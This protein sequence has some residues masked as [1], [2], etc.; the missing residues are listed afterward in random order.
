MCS[1]RLLAKK[2]WYNI[3]FSLVTGHGWV[4]T[5]NE[6]DITDMQFNILLF[7]MIEHSHD[8]RFSV[9]FFF[10]SARAIR[11]VTYAG[12]IS[13]N[14]ISRYFW[15]MMHYGW[16][17]RTGLTIIIPQPL[18][19]PGDVR[20]ELGTSVCHP[21]S[22]VVEKWYLHKTISLFFFQI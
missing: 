17:T 20:L 8:F 15:I 19:R 2:I 12:L 4:K 21:P 22:C 16:V 11:V 9:Y 13:P 3:P 1:L 5:L 7:S 10:S 14:L 6:D 18:T